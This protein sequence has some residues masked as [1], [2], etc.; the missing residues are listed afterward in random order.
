MIADVPVADH[1]EKMICGVKAQKRHNLT[2]DA[3]A[4]L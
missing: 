4:K 1:A 2:G 3:A